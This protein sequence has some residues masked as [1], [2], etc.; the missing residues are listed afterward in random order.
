MIVSEL[1]LKILYKWIDEVVA[2]D[3]WLIH[4]SGEC[5]YYIWSTFDIFIKPLDLFVSCLGGSLS[6]ARGVWGVGLPTAVEN[7]P[8]KVVSPPVNVS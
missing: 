7:S 3:N 8:D 5:H 1:T 6:I 4:R 2:E